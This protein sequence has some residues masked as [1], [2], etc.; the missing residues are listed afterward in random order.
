MLE[1]F[2]ALYGC[3]AGNLAVKTLCYGGLYISGGV[4]ARIRSYLQ[5]SSIF[6]DNFLDKGRMK[7]LMEK[8]PIMILT[9]EIGI[10]GAEEFAFRQLKHL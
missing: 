9:E 1:I 4:T 6:M 3:E 7:N 2:T 8:I 10:N 5:N